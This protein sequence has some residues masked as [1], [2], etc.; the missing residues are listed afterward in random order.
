M[1]L[2]CLPRWLL[3]L[4][5]LPFLSGCFGTAEK[6]HDFVKDVEGKAYDR[7][8]SAIDKY[9]EGKATQGSFQDIFLMEALELRREIRQ[10]P[11]PGHGP[12][13]PT[14][15]PDLLDDKTAYGQGPVVRIWCGGEAVPEEIW[16]DFIRIK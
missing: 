11:I 4:L 6:V 8:A 2:P 14:H 15:K 13:G 1:L 12:Q 10:R 3:L 9:C 5:I 7:V 16:Q